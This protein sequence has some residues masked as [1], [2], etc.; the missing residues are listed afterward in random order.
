MLSVSFFVQ[1]GI[2]GR[3]TVSIGCGMTPQI[4]M[5]M[6]KKHHM[7]IPYWFKEGNPVLLLQSNMFLVVLH[8]MPCTKYIHGS[9][10]KVCI[11]GILF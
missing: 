4:M 7:R 9:I 6:K 1:H 2:K 10:I 8:Q 3:Q 11:K 5:Y